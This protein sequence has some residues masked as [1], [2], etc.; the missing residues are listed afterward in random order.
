M[1]EPS[2]I[3]VIIPV[4]N[5]AEELVAC[6]HSLEKQTY[7]PLEI[8][9]V[10]D[11][12]AD[13]PF[14]RLARESFPVSYET[15]KLEANRGAPAARNEGFKRS[16]GGYVMFLD[17][18]AV[19]VPEAIKEL[20]RALV[21]DPSA[22]FAYSSFYFGRKFFR[23]MPFNAAELRKNN[24]IHTSGLIRREAFP[25][26]DESLKK[27]QDWDL[28][29]TIAER[30]GSGVWIDKP[31]LT[32]K[33]RT[34]SSRKFGMSQWLPSFVHRLPWPIFGWM[35]HEIRRYREAEVIIRNKHGI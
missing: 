13:R 25:G 15:V 22:A 16:H 6:L 14:E 7:R 8:I 4:Y 28:W 10:D 3:S 18:D 20:V 5:H 35:P 30:G 29:L 11:G 31:L 12:S 24:Y 33:P 1:N 17:A 21:A 34:A 2:L 26:F 9:V 19:L 27:F 32:L 23:G